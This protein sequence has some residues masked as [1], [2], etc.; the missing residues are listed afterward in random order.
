[1]VDQSQEDTQLAKAI[2]DAIGGSSNVTSVIYC[3]TR[4]R[5]TLKDLTKVDKPN[6]ENLSGVLG[7]QIKGNQLQ[8]VIGTHVARIFQVVESVLGESG[9]ASGGAK[10]NNSSNQNSEVAVKKFNPMVVLDVLTSIIS[11]IIPAFCACG[12]M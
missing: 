11:P 6:L 10:V 4:L 9:S 7:T 8:V 2:V 3:A 12:M 1:M 5:F